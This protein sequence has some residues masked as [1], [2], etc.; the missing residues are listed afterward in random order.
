MI[1]ATIDTETLKLMGLDPIKN[2]LTDDYWY[3][4]SEEAYEACAGGTN[5]TFWGAVKKKIEAFDLN[6]DSY[7]EDDAPIVF[8]LSDIDTERHYHLPE[9]RA[10]R[11]RKNVSLCQ[12]YIEYGVVTS[13]LGSRQH[14]L[15]DETDQLN[16]AEKAKMVEDGILETVPVKA[17]GESEYT[18][19]SAEDFTALYHGLVYQKY[20]WLFYLR[21]LND[22]IDTIEDIDFL[23]KMTF[24]VAL[25]DEYQEKLETQLK[26][27]SAWKLEV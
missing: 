25:P 20:Y 9:V 11:K 15:Y 8:E 13:L 16:F 17:D 26:A 5:I 14:F 12:E 7:T 3:P 10:N 19:I 23:H 1:Y 22:Y 24:E 18:F 6:R 27:L 2:R 21:A 4:I